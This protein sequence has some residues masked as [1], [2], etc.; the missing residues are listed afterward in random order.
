[1]LP[2]TIMDRSPFDQKPPLEDAIGAYID[3]L[4]K[5]RFTGKS[6]MPWIGILLLLILIFDCFYSIQPEEA[7]R[8]VAR[9]REV[10]FGSANMTEQPTLVCVLNSLL[11]KM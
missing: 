8:R 3:K 7:V 2:F 11:L 6:L 9:A 1:M 5:I 4:R 10:L